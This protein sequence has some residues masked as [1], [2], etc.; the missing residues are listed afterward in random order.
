MK[1]LI[2]STILLSFIS[3]FSNLSFAQSDTNN[4]CNNHNHNNID[5]VCFDEIYAFSNE[6]RPKLNF[7]NYF[8]NNINFFFYNFIR[9][10]FFS[11][12]NGTV[13]S[14]RKNFTS[15]NVNHKNTFDLANRYNFKMYDPDKSVFVIPNRPISNAFYSQGAKNEQNFS[16]F[17]AQK[18]DTFFS[19]N[20]K[21][22]IHTSNGLYNNQKTNNSS[23]YGKLY[24]NNPDRRYSLKSGIFNNSINQNENGGVA[25]PITQFQDTIVFDRQFAKTNLNTANNKFRNTTLFYKHSIK[26]NS[27]NNNNSLFFSNN[28]QYTANHRLFQAEFEDFYFFENVFF[29]PF[30]TSDSINIRLLTS[31]IFLSNFNYFLKP[32]I[33][34]INWFTGY[35]FEKTNT[36]NFVKRDQFL[37]HSFI[38]GLNLITS[39]NVKSNFKSEMLVRNSLLFD[40]KLNVKINADFEKQFDNS[41]LEKVNFDIICYILDPLWVQQYYMSNHFKWENTFEKQELLSFS[42]ALKTKLGAI[43]FRYEHLNNFVYYDTLSISKQAASPTN[44]LNLNYLWDFKI[45]H[46]TLSGTIGF[47][48]ADN[49][50]YIR[51]PETYTTFRIGYDIS[52]FKDALDLFFGVEAFYFSKFK[53]DVWSPAIMDFKIQ[54]DFEI[55]NFIYPNFFLSARISKAKFFLMIENFSAGILPIN[56]FAMPYYPRNDLFFRWGI[57]WNFIN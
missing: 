12:T 31:S 22:T 13:S 34:K 23:F 36:F 50:A 8:D 9:P 40:K 47:Q 7:N 38:L 49:N 43:S 15:S 2:V 53:A 21:Y 11:L 5:S 1:N 39:N 14:F 4:L 3:I 24:Y 19:V 42:G 51:I 44:I 10:N 32:N 29:Q 45:N 17:H 28:T 48:K 25:Y 33:N 18:I 20:L 54:N 46:F 6:I 27:S 26:L 16:F 35:K 37:T 57:S 41:F 55:G 56:Y 30:R 52:L